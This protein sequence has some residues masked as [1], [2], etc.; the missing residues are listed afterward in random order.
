MSP[1]VSK[2]QLIDHESQSLTATSTATKTNPGSLPMP[3]LQLETSLVYGNT[4]PTNTSPSILPMPVLQPETSSQ[5]AFSLS[6]VDVVSVK[7]ENFCPIPSTSAS[8]ASSTM[9]H[10]VITTIYSDNFDNIKLSPDSQNEFG[11][12]VAE[13]SCVGPRSEPDE[14]DEICQR[15]KAKRPRV[16]IVGGLLPNLKLYYESLA[17]NY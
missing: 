14:P 13:P 12:R 11:K 15:A 7:E 8:F 9:T 3:V 6:A 10:S 5:R 4:T 2:H 17:F 1:A 16:E